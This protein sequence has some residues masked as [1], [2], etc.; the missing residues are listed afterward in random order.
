MWMWYLGTGK[1]TPIN[2]FRPLSDPAEDNPN[3]ET[4]EDTFQNERPVVNHEPIEE[5][6]VDENETFVENRQ[7][8]VDANLLKLE[9][10]LIKMR[11]LYKNRIPNDPEGYEKALNVLENHIDRLPKSNDAILQKAACTFAQEAIS[12]LR[13]HKRKKGSIIPVQV[14]IHH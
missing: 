8:K 3:D 6:D 12:P 2:Y 7:E 14:K 10:I 5:M 13:V 9:S 4:N 11:D 1:E